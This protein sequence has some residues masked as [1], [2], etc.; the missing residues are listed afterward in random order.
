MF[1]CASVK[2]HV[3]IQLSSD[4]GPMLHSYSL[5]VSHTTNHLCLCSMCNFTLKIYAG[6]KII[7][8]IL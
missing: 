1:I 3:M 7:Y 4:E 8:F 2:F 6:S 5:F